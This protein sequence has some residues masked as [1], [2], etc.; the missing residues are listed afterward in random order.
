MNEPAPPDT[1]ARVDR[2]R[3]QWV[4]DD[5]NEGLAQAR[6]ALETFAEAPGEPQ[7]M[8]ACAEHLHSVRGVLEMLEVYGVSLL[9]DELEQLARAL[10]TGHVARTEDACE[11]LMQG[12]VQ[13]PLYLDL[14]VRGQPDNPIVLMPLLNDLRSVRGLGLLSENALF[15]PDLTAAL[16]LPAR[17][18]AL[19]GAALVE[20]LG[21]LR[22]RLQG[23][24][25]AWFRDADPGAS[26]AAIEALV[27]H[28]QK[29]LGEAPAARV[30][31]LARA[32]LDA[33]RAGGL[34]ATPAVKRVVGR[35]D[36]QL[37]DLAREPDL[38]LARTAP[39]DL[40][41]NLLYYSA[42][43]RAGGRWLEVVRGSFA[44]DALLAAQS[45]QGRWPTELFGPDL[46]TVSTVAAALRDILARVEDILDTFNRSSVRRIDD[47]RALEGL[48]QQ[49]ADTLGL[50]GRGAL[51][52]SVIQ[53][54]R[55][56]A[57]YMAQSEP[58]SEAQLLDIAAALLR[59]EAAINALP[60]ADV[61]SVD[62][63]G[64]TMAED[65][66]AASP[67]GAEAAAPLPDVAAADGLA[68]G[69]ELQARVIAEAR[70]ELLMVKD[71]IATYVRDDVAHLQVRA[72]PARIQR[73][74]GSM[75]MVDL[76]TAA[77]L[78]ER[79]SGHAERLLLR[80]N[81]RAPGGALELLADGIES[82]DYYLEAVAAGTGDS[83]QRMADAVTRITALDGDA[84]RRRADGEDDGAIRTVVM[85]DGPWPPAAD[86][87][88]QDQDGPGY[89]T[90]VLDQPPV[91]PRDP[92]D[93]NRL[94]PGTVEVDE[95][96][97]AG[98]EE[99]TL[100]GLDDA[101]AA[102]WPPADEGEADEEG[103][104]DGLSAGPPP[105]VDD[106][107]ALLFA[108][109]PTDRT[110]AVAADGDDDEQPGPIPDAVTRSLEQARDLLERLDAAPPE[111]GDASDAGSEVDVDLRE[112]FLEEA[113]EVLQALR[114]AV[115]RWSAN[116]RDGEALGAARR[117]FH[118]LKGSG[119]MVGA[120]DLGELSWGV[121]NLLNRVMDGVVPASAP[122]AALLHEALGALPALLGELRGAGP[123][124]IDV[125]A[126]VLRAERLAE[127]AASGVAPAG[128]DDPWLAPPAP[129][130]TPAPAPGTGAEVL[131]FPRRLAAA[132]DRPP[133]SAVPDDE[134]VIATERAALAPV[135]RDEA[136]RHL[137]TLRAVLHGAP[138][139]V[140]PLLR[141]L[142]T[143]TGA[144]RTAGLGE[145]ADVC[146]AAETLVADLGSSGQALSAPVQDY[147]LELVEQ[148]EVAVES[149]A[150]GTVEGLV[151]GAAL[152]ERARA[153]TLEQA[154]GADTGEALLAERLELREAFL[155]EAGDILDVFESVM[156]RWRQQGPDL[157]LLAELQRALHTLKGGARMAQYGAIA[158][159]GHELEAVTAL[160]AAGRIE[161]GDELYEAVLATQ[162]QLADML[163]CVVA[164]Q[165]LEPAT[166]LAER[167][168]ALARGDAPSPAATAVA[169]SGPAELPPGTAAPP[170][171]TAA[172]PGSDAID[173][174]AGA[175]RAERLTLDAS[176]LDALT[177][178]A[179]EIAIAQSR[180][181]GQLGALGQNVEELGQ[182]VTRLREQLR[183][184]ERETESQILYR[185]EREAAAELAP[186]GFDPLE[187]DR[188]TRIQELSRGLAESV[189]DL[190]NIQGTLGAL[191]RDAE[192]ILQA[193]A[194][195]SAELQHGLLQTRMVPVARLLP[196]LRRVL[197]QTAA[198]L[199]KA[200][201]LQVSGETIRIDRAILMPMG[202]ALEHLLRNS[203]DHGI[204]SPAA[205]D[206]AGKPP[207]GLVRLD[208]RREGNE[209]LLEL[210]DDG[211]G[212]R[213][214]AVRQ[215]AIERGLLQAGTPVSADDLLQLIFA[216]GLSTR[217][218]VT[219]IS[220]RGVGLDVVRNAVR[221]L[222][223]SV[224][225]TSAPEQ[226]A[227]FVLRLP[228]TLTV[229]QALMVMVGT[230]QLGL[231]LHSVESV[232]RVDAARA[233]A[234][235]AA[236]RPFYEHG[237]VRYPLCYL[238][239]VLGIAAP[240][241]RQARYP[242]VLLRAGDQR[243][244]LRVDDLRGRQEVVVKS[245]GPLL[246]A[247]PWIAGATVMGDGRVVLILDA[248]TLLEMA[249]TASLAAAEDGSGADQQGPL[250]MVV[251]DSITVRKV[252]GRFLQRNGMRVVTAR[253]GLEA[254]GMLHEQLPAAMLLDIEMPRMDG[255]ELATAV[256]NDARTKDLPIIM[257]TSRSGQ[258]HSERA[259][260]IGVDDYL[261]KPYHEAE[262][263][264]RIQRVLDP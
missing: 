202:A 46:D 194:R 73:V 128:V 109:P 150:R 157:S 41:K 160:A 78:F 115:P 193:Q 152:I 220:G 110:D 231:P 228:L 11:V 235:E 53:Q 177:G 124:D 17:P 226:G 154:G 240:D 117:A 44:L 259:A 255:F 10:R 230:E 5:V 67:G 40:Q 65:T 258:K 18:P 127:A 166:A 159:L 33:L 49:V 126:L 249:G 176:V 74:A 253:D 161:A 132:G 248:P 169:P 216:P 205:R 83:A 42:R 55:V 182:T 237:G 99:I 168:A 4:L 54:Q 219:Q 43:A 19:G 36:G 232:L 241:Y 59:V 156:Q 261:G 76:D 92:D 201:R 198:A 137:D 188:F 129:V 58:P 213:V 223:G 116:L 218:A 179:G 70:A 77:V 88:A 107:S 16:P 100:S 61:G 90:V 114:V 172:P 35:L 212:V 111:G 81:T 256:R 80:G 187:L 239:A 165:A 118:T 57:G 153:L 47:L 27:T 204:E 246:G 102:P 208:V 197:R 63:G 180:I 224:H 9:L 207:Q 136:A 130:S 147:L 257:I 244:A 93:A 196:R 200:A 238:G 264:Q 199:G 227:R 37:R 50:L 135:L 260:Q 32:V 105:G 12:I 145:V 262:L 13:V 82:L 51:R 64:D 185:H 31:W 139:S 101:L 30:W 72:V 56:L 20:H 23:A 75:R 1:P 15:N 181:E 68:E 85:R 24:L 183:A 122:V 86:S 263:L 96:D 191:A 155:E 60:D 26:V 71:A 3:L 143:L 158:D 217:E 141:P 112:V 79:W 186:A 233:R 98:T 87:D 48:L 52:R 120:Q 123:A 151:G 45:E 245:V 14:L 170:P 214:E 95:Y 175:S 211:A 125:R 119:R 142:H 104:A 203:V 94:Q 173:L 192:D 243:F 195:S 234:L 131:A 251:D 184:L 113:A 138:G 215:Q 222:G 236:P 6:Q 146:A 144:A 121:E 149:F 66:P 254:L 28:M 247:I 206:A 134:R 8:E 97:D 69:A 89:D 38:A 252:T 167:I 229:N 209:V 91:F 163:D 164:H 178:Q 250:I 103:D 174:A 162:D 171:G 221:Q 210:A 21:K 190:S 62:D 29:L 148:V 84:A 2:G 25:L 133:A 106:V 108:A 39:A 242:V 140:Q 22:P 225:V 34:Q 189:G 7:P